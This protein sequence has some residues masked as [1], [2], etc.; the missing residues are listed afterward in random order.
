MRKI[1]EVGNNLIEKYATEEQKD[2]VGTFEILKRL[3]ENNTN[4]KH[5]KATA[6]AVDFYVL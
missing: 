2:P 4:V 6:S 1:E 5:K 3:T